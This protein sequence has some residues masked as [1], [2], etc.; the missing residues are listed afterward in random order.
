[1]LGDLL[2]PLVHHP[3]VVAVHLD[4]VARAPEELRGRLVRHG[5]L[6]DRGRAE[7]PQRLRPVRLGNALCS[8]EVALVEQLL[9]LALGEGA[10]EQALQV[11]GDL[12]RGDGI[13][14][15]RPTARGRDLDGALGDGSSGARPALG[16]RR[17][18]LR[19]RHRGRD[20]VVLDGVVFLPPR[21]PR[22]LVHDTVVMSR[23]T[24]KP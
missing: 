19:H 16:L 7:D 23:L 11:F 15:G 2:E 13:D 22:R 12:V 3:D 10:R 8:D 21:H 4:R 20:W 6:P 24:R 1:M 18:E 5:G 14:H 17:Q 9:P